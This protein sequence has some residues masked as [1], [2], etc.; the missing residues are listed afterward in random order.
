MSMMPPNRLAPFVPNA[1]VPANVQPRTPFKLS[2]LPGMMWR[3]LQ[4][5]TADWKKQKEMELKL[6]EAMI[7]R[8]LGTPQVDPMAQQKAGLAPEQFRLDTPA[9]IQKSTYLRP[10]PPEPPTPA[11]AFS[12]ELA[13]N[14]MPGMNEAPFWRMKY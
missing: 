9:P 4:D 13:G 1:P 8:I 14:I 2:Q 11:P 5:A 12:P 3:G 6:R 7:S 10:P